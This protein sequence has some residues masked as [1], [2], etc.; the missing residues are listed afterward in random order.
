MY[1]DKLKELI[2]NEKLEKRNW[3]DLISFYNRKL[4]DLKGAYSFFYTLKEDAV[5][6]V[7]QCDI[8]IQYFEVELEEHK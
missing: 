2:E 3:L 1:N 8:S 5:D 4:D 7:V 6:K